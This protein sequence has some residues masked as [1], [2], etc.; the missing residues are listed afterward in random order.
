MSYFADS[1]S[2]WVA[3]FLIGNIH[4]IALRMKESDFIDKDFREAIEIM[5]VELISDIE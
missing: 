5:W 2:R 1:T 4:I 3:D